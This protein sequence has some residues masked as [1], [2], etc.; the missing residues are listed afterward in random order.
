MIDIY[1]LDRLVRGAGV[2]EAPFAAAG[3]TPLDPYVESLPTN[4]PQAL[5]AVGQTQPAL[6]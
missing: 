2:V 4:N 5:F 6:T 1:M 3:T